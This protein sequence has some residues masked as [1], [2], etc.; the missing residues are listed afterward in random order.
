MERRNFL[1]GLIY[2]GVASIASF[3]SSTLFSKEPAAV[4]SGGNNDLVAVMGGEPAQMYAKAIEAMGGISRFVKRGQ[5][6]VV[7]PNIG[8]DKSPEEGANTNPELVA[9]I[10]KDCL[11]AGAA[12]VVV[13]DHS[14]DHWQS[15]YKNSGIEDAAKAAGARIAFAHDEKY[16]K[17]VKIPKGKRLKEAKI[18]SEILDCDA[19]INVPVLKTHGGARMTISM[20]NFMGIVWDRRFLHA[21]DLQQCIA[22]CSTISKMPVLNIVDAYRIMT[23][24][25]PK[26]KSP[27]DV[28]LAK[29]LFI[30][31]DIV[32]ADTAAVKFFSQFRPMDINSVSHIGIAEKMNIGTT[33]LDSLSVKRI[34]I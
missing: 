27:D 15:C 10:V 3:K 19:W 25:G 24:N 16:Y 29:A 6:I 21:N 5:K 13:F 20:K 4:A 23:Q 33:D 32:A 30:S 18:H 34:K 28:Q 22:D 1:K 8:W 11:R 26:G 17:S 7:K 12:E 2:G 14:C 9:A 31:T